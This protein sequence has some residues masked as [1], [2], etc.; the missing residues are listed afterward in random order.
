[1]IFSAAKINEQDLA[2][3]VVAVDT[4]FFNLPQIEK[5]ALVRNFVQFFNNGP[6]VLMALD[7]NR[8][9]QCYGR[10]D[11]VAIISAVPLSQFKWQDYDLPE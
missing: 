4:N 5:A 9:M 2:I 10:P 8:E 3:T 11:L 7:E 6:T 1:M